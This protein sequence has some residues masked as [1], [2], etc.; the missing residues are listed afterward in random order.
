MKKL[1]DSLQRIWQT[2]NLIRNVQRFEKIKKNVDKNNKKFTTKTTAS[3]K[4]G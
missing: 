1:I 3:G 2:K 4:V